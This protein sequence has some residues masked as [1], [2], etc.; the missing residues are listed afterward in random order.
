MPRGDR[1]GRSGMGPMTGRAMGFCAGY[2]TPGYANNGFGRMG[3]RGRGLGLGRGYGFGM[4]RGFGLG[5][6]GYM[7]DNVP[8]HSEEM[9]LSALEQEKNLLERE[10]EAINGRL[11][12]FKKE[13]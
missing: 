5:Y 1:T 8:V 11:K 6:G 13:D 4:N 2:N 9:E 7:R 3:G 10:L 12:T